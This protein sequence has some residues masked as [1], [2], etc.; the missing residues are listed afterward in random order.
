[1]DEAGGHSERSR[2]CNWLDGRAR[3][4]RYGALGTLGDVTEKRPTDE[5]LT[6]LVGDLKA[7]DEDRKTHRP[8]TPGYHDASDRMENL[9]REVYRVAIDDELD[10]EEHAELE[11][12]ERAS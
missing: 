10:A 7:A 9:S 5:R 3:R 8:S 2:N 4:G 11:A 1:V 6:E 12:K